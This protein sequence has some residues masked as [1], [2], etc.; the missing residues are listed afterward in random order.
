[1]KIETYKITVPYSQ[2][3]TETEYEATL[4]TYTLEIFNEIGR[5]KSPAVIICPGG[6]Y[7]KVADKEGEPV[8]V[9]FAAHGIQAFVLNYSVPFVPFPVAL[10]ELAKATAYVRENADKWDIDPDNISVCGFSAGGHL[11]AS[12]GVHW[13]SELVKNSL[14]FSNEHKPNSLILCYPVITSGKYA[15]EGSMQNI[16]SPE[17]IFEDMFSLEDHVSTDTP[18]T[19]IWHCADD[20][21]VPVENTLL[22]TL[23]LSRHKI[24]FESHIYPFGGHGISLCDETTS[25]TINEHNE[26]CSE[27]FAKAT[28]WIK[29]PD[30]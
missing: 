1:M 14:G 17:N 9:R 10:L 15:H 26:K 21:V 27:W 23:S 13:N 3:D 5:K 19:F 18:R 2:N 22:F 12:L 6:G 24:S 7:Y 16:S 28:D 8:A 30:K 29:N 25:Y 11:A 4:T 20:D